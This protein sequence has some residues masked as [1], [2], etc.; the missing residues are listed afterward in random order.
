MTFV[1][2]TRFR[3]PHVYDLN[4]PAGSWNAVGELASPAG[5]LLNFTSAQSDAELQALDEDSVMSITAVDLEAESGPVQVTVWDGPI[6]GG[7][8]IVMRLSVG[9]LGGRDEWVGQVYAQRGTPF[10]FECDANV[11]GQLTV[12]Q[13]KIPVAGAFTRS[14][15]SRPRSI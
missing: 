1:P 3:F 15:G 5:R 10:V 12:Q 4:K 6:G 8:N 9:S 2:T 14:D 13:Q 11:V 7:G